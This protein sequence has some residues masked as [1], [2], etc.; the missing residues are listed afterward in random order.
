[1]SDKTAAERFEALILSQY[2]ALF[3]AAYRMTRS[4]PDAEDLVQEVCVRAYPRLSELETLDQPR[5]WLLRVLYRLVVDRSRRYDRRNVDALEDLDVDALVSGEPD[6]AEQSDALQDRER[7]ER[8]WQRLSDE[9]RVVLALHDIEGYS[10]AELNELLGLKQG[11]LKSRLHRAR[12][13]LGKLLRRED[14]PSSLKAGT[15]GAA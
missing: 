5:Y 1:V 2:Q 13:R 8:A 15:G 10:L 11:T 7:L 4:V 12:V 3:R 6:P 9:E 14:K